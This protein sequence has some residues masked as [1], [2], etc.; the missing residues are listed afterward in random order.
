[1]ADR[2]TF[3]NSE[4]GFCVPRVK[5]RDQ[6]NLITLVGHVAMISV[7]FIRAAPAGRVAN[8]FLWPELIGAGRG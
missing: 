1:M 7:E 3:R 8:A 5:T 4:N 2:V 6:R